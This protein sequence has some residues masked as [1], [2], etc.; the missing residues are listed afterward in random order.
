MHNHKSCN[1]FDKLHIRTRFHSNNWIESL[2]DLNLHFSHA[3][4]DGLTNYSSLNKKVFSL[5]ELKLL[6]EY[7]Q[8]HSIC[9]KSIECLEIISGNPHIF[10]A[11]RQYRIAER[12]LNTTVTTLNSIIFSSVAFLGGFD[13]I[14]KKEFSTLKVPPKKEDDP[15]LYSIKS[16]IKSFNKDTRPCAL[17]SS[18][19]ELTVENIMPLAAVRIIRNSNTKT[20]DDENSKFDAE[21]AVYAY[22]TGLSITD[23]HT[24]SD[25]N[26]KTK[27]ETVCAFG[28]AKTDTIKIQSPMPGD[29]IITLS[30]GGTSY[31]A[32]SF[33][34]K[35]LF[36]SHA[37]SALRTVCHG[38]SILEKLLEL[39]AAIEITGFKIDELIISKLCNPTDDI[40]IVIKKGRQD[41][42]LK[43]AHNLG[44]ETNLIGNI[45]RGCTF[46]LSSKGKVYVNLKLDL[47]KN[48]PLGVTTA[49]IHDER[50]QTIVASTSEIRQSILNEFKNLNRENNT[51]V[52]YMAGGN[53]LFAPM[54]GVKNPISPLVAGYDISDFSE[55]RSL[56]LGVASVSAIFNDEPFIAT[57][58]AA[59]LAVSKLISQGSSLKHT[60]VSLHCL[61]PANRQ[62]IIDT[63]ASVAF[64]CFY[65][66]NQLDIRILS[67]EFTPIL[68]DAEISVTMIASAIGNSKISTT[69]IFPKKEKVYRLSLHRDKYFVPDFKYLLKLYTLVNIGVARGNITAATVIEDN[70]ISTII[71]S[72][73]L[74][75]S[76]F[77]FAKSTTPAL[78]SEVGDFLITAKNMSDFAS[79][80]YEYLGFVN[81]GENI[82]SFNSNLDFGH[83]SDMILP[84]KINPKLQI[85]E[86]SL[87]QNPRHFDFSVNILKPSVFIPSVDIVSSTQLFQAFNRAGATT[88]QET[89]TDRLTDYELLKKCAL[90]ISKSQILALSACNPF[91][92]AFEKTSRYYKFFMNPIIINAVNKLLENGGLILGLGEGFRA[93]L[94]L[95]LIQAS[96]INT[97]SDSKIRFDSSPSIDG[98]LSLS[99]GIVTSV[100]SPWMKGAELKQEFSIPLSLNPGKL[101]IPNDEIT[102]LSLNGQIVS[103]FAD[104]TLT[105]TMQ[106]PY[107]PTNADYAVEGLSSRDGRILGRTAQFERISKLKNAPEEAEFNLFARG[108]NFFK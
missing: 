23:F 3:E 50:H 34:V 62:N 26:Y 98:K 19:A 90:N 37:Q 66:V 11:V 5:F 44:I 27:I 31:S 69:R 33:A 107:N 92:T 76:G 89:I 97:K 81:N 86:F 70:V 8:S 58:N 6:C 61:Y 18:T 96:N 64:A 45:S 51:K 28:I 82:K 25:N 79:I 14:E 56:V 17:Y 57:I 35:D 47:L 100:L 20:I 72:L 1:N 75:G 104:Y 53:V 36:D 102:D 91:C 80:D 74:D 13:L 85:S 2:N 88:L 4:V 105:P 83:I 99:T 9:D 67:A 93:L 55:N 40:V 103:L 63:P 49:K 60:A 43:T 42:F 15:Y 24:I 52:D 87:Y 71:K 30:Q 108:V 16:N 59:V 32:H 7:W 73:L 95:K 22:E 48:K 84:I 39:N 68:D 65:V 101:V 41:L 12:E 29:K 77:S 38:R 21:S 106:F 46:K 10:T 78:G 54:G 94:E